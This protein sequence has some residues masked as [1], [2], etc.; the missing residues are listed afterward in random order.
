[1]ISNLKTN[2]NDNKESKKDTAAKSGNMDI[3]KNKLIGDKRKKMI[4]T[5]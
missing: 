4:L 5:E 3:N 1:L 2:V